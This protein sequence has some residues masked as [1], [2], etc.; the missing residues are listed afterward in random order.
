MIALD[1]FFT[2]LPP[3]RLEELAC[4]YELDSQHSVALSGPSVFL[5]L[6]N[7][8]LNHPELSLRLLEETYQQQTGRT[9]DHSSFGR[10]LSRMDPAYFADLFAKLY[11]H[12]APQATAG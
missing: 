3:K 11:G 6:L 12:L 5:C 7:G 10:C 2:L 1:Q 9:I 8:L 4:R